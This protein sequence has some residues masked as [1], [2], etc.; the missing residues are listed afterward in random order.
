VP[1]RDLEDLGVG[2]IFAVD[3]DV[4]YVAE[5]DDVD[6]AVRSLWWREHAAKADALTS[7]ESARARVL[8]ASWELDDAVTA[9]H[10][11]G[12]DRE[13]ISRAAGFVRR[14]QRGL[15]ADRRARA[16]ALRADRGLR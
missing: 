6:E 15:G 4:A 9:A 11:A 5:R 16:V 13:A 2:R 8:A 3:Q 1:R 12:V 7:V 10:A 14:T